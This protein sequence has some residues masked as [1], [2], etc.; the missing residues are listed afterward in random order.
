VKIETTI[1]RNLLTDDA[2]LRAVIPFLKEEYFAVSSERRMLQAIQ[3]FVEQYN[4]TPTTEAL[5]ITFQNDKTITEDDF[6]SLGSMLED[7]D[8]YVEPA[9]ID[10]LLDVTEK[11]CKDKAVFNAIQQSIV[12]FQGEDKEHTPDAIPAMLQEALAINFDNSVGHSYFD[13]AEERYDYYTK[14]E[15]KLRFDIDFL[16][17][18]TN[19]GV[20]GKTLLMITGAINVGK[21]LILCHLAGSYMAQGKNV[22][23]ITLELSEPEI[24]KRIDANLMNVSIN[25]LDKLTKKSFLS[26]VDKIRN[27]TEGRLHVKEYPAG[28]YHVG[29]FRALISEL[30]LKQKFV[31]DVII[32]DMLD[33]CASSRIKRGE[34]TNSYLKSVAQEL[35][36]LGQ[37]N[38]VP[39]WSAS[40]FT[41]TGM[42]SSDPG[43]TD[44][45]YAIGISEVCDL[46]LAV[47]QDEKLESL[48]Q[49][50][51]KQLK[52]RLNS[53]SVNR[54]A[55]VGVDLTRQ[56]LYNV[57]SIAQRDVQSE[58]IP[59]TPKGRFD[60]SK[61]DMTTGEILED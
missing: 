51:F 54:K 33:G 24:T 27:K 61:I 22:L 56:R 6:K 7:M 53:K 8:T 42:T 12:I 44:T 55:V 49:Y 21:T 28:G 15:S 45:A 59:Y 23:Y 11:F 34:N 52:N 4:S 25:E 20:P 36:G 17:L 48:G 18:V 41:R 47:S 5:A 57:E 26:R 60:M 46:Q 31:P 40:Q 29:H 38:N 19:G 50:L 9:K 30:A 3:G 35:R 32:V 37:E 10:W 39:V 13:D 58:P 43:M 1:F 16:N 2:Y 14:E